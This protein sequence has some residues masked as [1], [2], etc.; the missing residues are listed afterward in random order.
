M[1]GAEAETVPAREAEYLA[2]AS[3]SP[4]TELFLVAG[5]GHT[6]GVRHPWAGSTPALEE[7]VQRTVRFLSGALG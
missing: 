5:G 4:R 7:V 6:F 3:G 2:H 1:H